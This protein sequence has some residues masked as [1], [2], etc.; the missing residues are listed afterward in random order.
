MKQLYSF[1]V[2]NG[3]EPSK[4]IIKKPTQ[5]ELEDGEIEYS[6]ALCHFIK[7]GILTKHMLHKQFADVGGLLP[8]KIAKEQNERYNELYEVQH[9][10]AQFDALPKEKQETK[11]RVSLV[12]RYVDI[13]REIGVV[14]QI[15]NQAYNHTAERKAENRLSMWWFYRLLHVQKA[16]QT[17][18]FKFFN[19]DDFEEN[20]NKFHT[21][22]EGE[23]EFFKSFGERAMG[24]VSFW[25]NS[26]TPPTDES[27]KEFDETLRKVLNGEDDVVEEQPEVDEVSD[28][29]FEENQP[30]RKIKAPKQ[31]KLTEKALKEVE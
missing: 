26:D 25:L 22:F 4:I 21:L 11:K 17:E 10:I 8:E 9:D 6:V 15:Y 16:G 30:K 3:D 27:F 28:K 14:E 12:G 19:S 31:K 29:E 7:R 2:P 13:K 18:P 5:R 23:D 24:I 20:Q 1:E